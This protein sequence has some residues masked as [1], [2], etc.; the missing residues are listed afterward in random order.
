MTSSAG[1]SSVVSS[2]K[3]LSCLERMLLREV[4]KGSHASALPW[5]VLLDLVWD[6]R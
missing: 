4:G 2:S 5:S 3:S 1:V 6:A